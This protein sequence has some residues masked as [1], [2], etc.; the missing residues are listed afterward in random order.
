MKFQE[1]A[2]KLGVKNYSEKLIEVYENL[3]QVCIDPCDL[4]LIE[5]IDREYD[6]L[7]EYA[8]QVKEAAIAIKNDPVRYAWARTVATAIKTGVVQ[9]GKVI[10]TPVSDETPAGDW[11]PFLILLP[12]LPDVEAFYRKLGF[13]DEDVERILVSF[14]NCINATKARVGRPGYNRSYFNWQ[15][16]YVRGELFRFQSFNYELKELPEG[17]ILKNRTTGEIQPL[18]SAGPYHR[19][20]MVLGSAGFEDEEGSFEVSF[21]ETEEA[22]LG[23]PAIGNLVVNEKRSYPKSEWECVLRPGD[24]VVSV[25][26][27]AKTD[28]S[29]EAVEKSYKE[30]LEF[31]DK[32][33]PDFKPKAYFCK[34]WLLDPQLEEMLGSQSKISQFLNGFTKWPGISE[35]KEI[36]GF[37]FIGFKGDYKD[38]PEDTTLMRKLKAHYLE[39]KHI[40]GTCGILFR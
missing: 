37:V 1:I 3:D 5:E 28:L 23:Y 7:K 14:Y 10:P 18:M 12:N 30:G 13:N 15:L 8:D 36:F 21:T 4:A 9:N 33:F 32:F 11:M 19:S 35:G 38:L 2:E 31:I 40:L 20:G 34:S 17:Y 25:H 16:I 26:I 22:Y 24:H 6:V 27:P 29:P 39:G